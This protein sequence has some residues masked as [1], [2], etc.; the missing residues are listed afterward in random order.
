MKNPAIILLVTICTGLL[1]GCTPEAKSPANAVHL[2]NRLE[3]ALEY[4]EKGDYV[5]AQAKYEE[6]LTFDPEAE[7]ALAGVSRMEAKRTEAAETHYHSGIKHLKRGRNNAAIADFNASLAFHGHEG[8]K[9]MLYA[10]GEGMKT[11]YA[12]HTVKK[13]DTLARIAAKYYED[14][15][16]KMIIIDFNRGVSE[17]GA[18][19]PGSELLIPYAGN[20]VGTA[21]YV[22]H[23]IAPGQSISRLAIIYYGNYK[24]WPII[25]KYNKMTNATAVKA[26]QKIK[27]PE[28]GEVSL[29]QLESV[30]AKYEQ[31]ALYLKE[32][33]TH[34]KEKNHGEAVSEFTKALNLDIKRSSV[35]KHLLQAYLGLAEKQYRAQDWA[36]AKAAYQAALKLDKNCRDCGVRIKL[37]EKRLTAAK[38]DDAYRQRAVELFEAGEYGK[39]L[40]QFENHGRTIE[41]FNREGNENFQDPDLDRYLAESHFKLGVQ[42]YNAG[43][44]ALAKQGFMTALGYESGCP[45]CTKYIKLCNEAASK[46]EEK[47]METTAET[48]PEKQSETTAEIQPETPV[49]EP[50]ETSGEKQPD[51][52]EEKQPETVEE[53]QPEKPEKPDEKMYET[54]AALK[55]DGKYEEA[56]TGFEA[57]RREIER[58]N[59]QWDTAYERP[60]LSGEI[61]ECRFELGMALFQDKKYL[62][63]AERFQEALSDNEDCAKCADY[64]KRS[65]EEF[66]STHYM[67]GHSFFAH[68]ET[69]QLPIEEGLKDLEIAIKEFELVS[70]LDPGYKDVALKMET[71]RNRYRRLA[72]LLER[73]KGN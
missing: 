33:K 7:A 52:V 69:P 6:A 59:R 31:W 18:L 47:P 11:G 35:E 20:S 15:G 4:E 55:A 10:H 13:G 54:A 72:E 41:A 9:M 56:L 5:A 3:A 34:L 45:E 73:T 71:A 36:G 44:Y 38:P 29:D 40:V 53:K 60:E 48:D 57:Y 30:Q 12:V 22:V 27:I 67:R 49:E 26:G 43:E 61:S 50:A 63:A 21:N 42:R 17:E 28:T 46:P 37:C 51:T 39:A 66:L 65:K 64:L 24:K 2:N 1:F 25:S 62:E 16:M 32:G 19:K 68:S 8:A 58:F 14:P 23:T 70:D